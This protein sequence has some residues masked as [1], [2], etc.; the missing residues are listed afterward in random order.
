VERE[1]VSACSG[2]DLLVCDRKSQSFRLGEFHNGLEAGVISEDD[3]IIE[4][5]ELTSGRKPGRESEEEITICE[6][7]RQLATQHCPNTLNFQGFG[8]VDRKDPCMS[9][10]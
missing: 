1:V 7:S 9:T 5:G 3:P 10:V 4:L 2:A 6:D 8:A